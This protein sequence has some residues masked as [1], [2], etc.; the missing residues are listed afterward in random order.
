MTP[1]PPFPPFP[2]PGY[3]TMD[4]T[5]KRRAGVDGVLRPDAGLGQLEPTTS[6]ARPQDTVNLN[7]PL[8]PKLLTGGVLLSA[9]YF[10][11]KGLQRQQSNGHDA[12]IELGEESRLRM[13]RVAQRRSQRR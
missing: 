6:F 5:K 4:H 11:L 10:T 7:A 2:Q 9:L 12:L 1:F 13:Q 3:S 8:L